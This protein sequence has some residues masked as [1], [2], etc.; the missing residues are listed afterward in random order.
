MFIVL[1]GGVLPMTK[2]E[3][4][5]K[6]LKSAGWDSEPTTALALLSFAYYHAAREKRETS[7]ALKVTLAAISTSADQTIL[8]ACRR[9]ED[10]EILIQKFAIAR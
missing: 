1:E 8:T 9:C 7:G 6:Q 3:S 10:D 5:H 2:I 4:W